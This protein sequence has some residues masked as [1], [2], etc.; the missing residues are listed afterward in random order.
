M[1]SY[2]RFGGSH[3]ES[4]FENSIPGGAMNAQTLQAQVQAPVTSASRFPA[5]R[6]LGASQNAPR[7]EYAPS[8]GIFVGLGSHRS[9]LG[10]RSSADS[11]C[12][13]APLT[14]ACRLRGVRSWLGRL[15]VL[16]GRHSLFAYRP[17]VSCDRSKLPVSCFCAGSSLE[18]KLG[19]G[20]A[21]QAAGRVARRE[22]S[23]RPCELSCL[24]TGTVIPKYGNREIPLYA[25]R[26]RL[27]RRFRGEKTVLQIGGVNG[28]VFGRGEICA[29]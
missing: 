9:Q 25:T 23:D 17:A 24:L 14:S 11:L 13:L 7:M 15:A 10:G 29:P 8:R 3:D 5:P 26:H 21:G 4:L 22:R 16:F 27:F 19:L 20:F 2:N 18:T 12:C 6:Q 28:T 1:R